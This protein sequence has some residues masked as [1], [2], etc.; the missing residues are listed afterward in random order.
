MANDEEAIT[1]AM[2]SDVKH[3][4]KA[5]RYVRRCFGLGIFGYVVCYAVLS[6]LGK[7]QM[8]T[9]GERRYSETGL[10]VIDTQEWQP[11]GL[12]FRRWKGTDGKLR[13]EGNLCGY[14][15]SPMIVLDRACVH[16]T[17]T[18]FNN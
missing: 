18:F 4:T 10:G 16:R 12:L 15:Y 7:W 9:S 1:K 13:T 6:L 17:A 11:K 2:S 8:V 5:R 3:G 14:I